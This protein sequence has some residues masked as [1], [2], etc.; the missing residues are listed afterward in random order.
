MFVRTNMDGWSPVVKILAR[1]CSPI[2]QERTNV[3]WTCG[4]FGSFTAIPICSHNEEFLSAITRFAFHFLFTRLLGALDVFRFYERGHVTNEK[5]LQWSFLRPS[6]NSSSSSFC[7]VDGQ[8][9]SSCRL[10]AAFYPGFGQ[11]QRVGESVA[12][13]QKASCSTVELHDLHRFIVLLKQG[14]ECC[15]DWSLSISL[16]LFFEHHRAFLRFLV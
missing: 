3:L 7:W 8:G 16:C 6:Q 9:T 11:V 4:L 5:L 12:Q 14:A 2:S 13:R 15:Q 1:R 10:G